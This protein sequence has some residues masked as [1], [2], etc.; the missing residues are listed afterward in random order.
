MSGEQAAALQ[1]TTSSGMPP[2]KLSAELP[3]ITTKE[4]VKQGN[5]NNGE[6]QKVAIIVPGDSIKENQHPNMSTNA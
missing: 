6:K 3:T 5:S 1:N 4:E 2:Q